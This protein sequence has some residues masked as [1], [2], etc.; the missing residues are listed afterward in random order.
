MNP[1][2]GDRESAHPLLE[3]EYGGVG[4]SDL[5]LTIGLLERFRA[6]MS[7][8][9]VAFGEGEG[10]SGRRGMSSHSEQIS[11]DN[12]ILSVNSE[13]KAPALVL[14]RLVGVVSADLGFKP[15]VRVAVGDAAVVFF[16]VG[17]ATMGGESS[18]Y[19]RDDG[20]GSFDGDLL[21]DRMRGGDNAVRLRGDKGVDADLKVDAPADEISFFLLDVAVSPDLMR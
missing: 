15:F 18:R 6:F 4:E 5:A 10:D 7:V 9:F 11:N 21:P 19:D 1:A 2:E 17:L 14:F 12:G 20:A 3:G 13:A 8:S 16:G